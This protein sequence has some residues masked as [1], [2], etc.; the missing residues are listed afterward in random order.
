M[1]SWPKHGAVWVVIVGILMTGCAT[2]ETIQ[3]SGDS[4]ELELDMEDLVLRGPTRGQT[5]VFQ[6]LFFQFGKNNSFL[7]AEQKALEANSSTILIS[8]IRLKTF[9]G[10]QIPTG[11][12][13][14]LGIP[15]QDIRIIGWEVYSVGG[16]GVDLIPRR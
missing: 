15:L 11:W 4:F 10:L 8:R 14:A 7:E 16:V 5:R 2:Q 12:L 9:E 6:I 13:S 3:Q 1:R